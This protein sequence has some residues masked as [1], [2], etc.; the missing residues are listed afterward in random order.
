MN[1]RLYFT[2][3]W[4][5]FDFHNNPFTDILGRRH[6]VAIDSVNPNLVITLNKKN[7]PNA[8][9]LYYNA[10]E[11]YYPNPSPEIA[12]HFIGSFF[13]DYENYTRF[14]TYYMYIS[15]FIKNNLHS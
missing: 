3:M 10:G 7:Y 8:L 15:H 1:I 6:N 2:E 5:G 13:L 4:G 9:T 12:D 14:P 11:P